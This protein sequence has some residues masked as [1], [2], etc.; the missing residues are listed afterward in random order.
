MIHKDMVIVLQQLVANNFKFWNVKSKE[1]T[2]FIFK[3][4]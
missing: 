2:D 1:I 4:K 3:A